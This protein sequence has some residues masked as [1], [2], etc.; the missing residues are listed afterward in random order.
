MKMTYPAEMEK[1]HEILGKIEKFATNSG[2]GKDRITQFLILS[3][4][5]IVNIM[6][7]AYAGDKGPLSIE[8]IDSGDNISMLLSDE[9]AEFNP[10]EASEPDITSDIESREI[11]GMGIFM[12][13]KFAEDV[14][15]KREKG[16][17]IL[18]VTYLK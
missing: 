11:G 15:Y 9:G 5:L 3:E 2:C 7:Y 6:S 4:E 13:K 17:N 1:L 18:T 16:R 8:L 10:L 14:S 12:V